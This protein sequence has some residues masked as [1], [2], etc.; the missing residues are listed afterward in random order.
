MLRV[1]EYYSGILFLTTNRVESL[2]PAF[3]SRVHCA[4]RYA[5]L[6]FSSRE[7]IWADLLKRV[8]MPRAAD[9]DVASL[10]AHQLNG[11]QVKNALQLALALAGSESAPL[12]QRHLEETVELTTAFVGGIETDQ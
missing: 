9:I 7:K 11:R 12:A 4:L 3:Q 1:L 8:T 6:D 2:D 5:P 10:A